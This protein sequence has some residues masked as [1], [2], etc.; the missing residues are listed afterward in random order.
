MSRHFLAPKGSELKGTNVIICVSTIKL[1]L[2]S[3][4]FLFNASSPKALIAQ[5]GGGGHSIMFMPGSNV[6]NKFFFKVK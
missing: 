3:V 4:E 2:C 5:Y 6:V 1:D